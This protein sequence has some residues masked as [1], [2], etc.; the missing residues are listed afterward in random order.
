MEVCA[1]RQVNHKREYKEHAFEV[2]H[3]NFCLTLTEE[4][5]MN[6]FK[7]IAPTVAWKSDVHSYSHILCTVGSYDVQ[8]EGQ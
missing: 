2:D 3:F 5:K 8:G 7:R 1:I 4:Y 6:K